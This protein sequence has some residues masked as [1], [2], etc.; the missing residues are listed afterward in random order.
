[1][2]MKMFCDRSYLVRKSGNNTTLDR[3][4]I[5]LEIEVAALWRVVFRVCHIKH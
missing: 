1:V 5:T 2:A 3:F 4:A